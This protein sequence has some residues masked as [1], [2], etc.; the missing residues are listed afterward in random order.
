MVGNVWTGTIQRNYYENK[1]IVRINQFRLNDDSYTYYKGV[2]NQS[3]AD[4]KMFDPLPAQL[5]GNITCKSDPETLVLG[6]FEVSSVSTRSWSVLRYG[7][8]YP[9]LFTGV[10]NIYP[11]QRG[12]TID[13]APDFWI[14]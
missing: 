5:Y 3:A 1:R 2:E 10:P 9:I 11:P 6:F 4:G 7:P 14:N 8:A 12:F 13:K